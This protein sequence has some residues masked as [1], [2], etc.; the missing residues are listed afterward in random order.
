VLK[1]QLD[2]WDAIAAK[3]SERIRCFRK[4]THLSLR[5]PERAVK[6]QADT[7]VPAALAYNQAFSKATAKPRSEEGLTRA[8]E[9]KHH[10]A[11]PDGVFLGAT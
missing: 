2:V 6:W 4:C 11:S 9:Q 7:V 8:Y 5:S 1:A 10:P 3:K